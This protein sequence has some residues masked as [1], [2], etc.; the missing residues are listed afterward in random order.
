MHRWGLLMYTFARFIVD[1]IEQMKSAGKQPKVL[2]LMRDA[3]LPSIVCEALTG[4]ALG[5]RVHISRF[6]AYAASFR[7]TNDVEQ[8]LVDVVKSN[9]FRE[10]SHQLLLPE[11]RRTHHQSR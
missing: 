8:Y 7:T 10:I 9:R 2:F 3:Y 5:K 11:K 6:A 1:E 4:Q